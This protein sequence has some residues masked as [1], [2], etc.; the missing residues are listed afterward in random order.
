MS[1]IICSNCGKDIE[2]FKM[3]LHER[4]CSLNVRKC[5]LCDEP[6][7]I[8]EYEEHKIISHPDIKC[9]FCG[10]IFRNLEYNSHE[11]IC[12]KKL[13]ECKYCGLYMKEKELKEHEY[14]CG[15]K[16][17]NC[18]YCKKSVTKLEYDLH[19]EYACEIK[20]RLNKKINKINNENKTNNFSDITKNEKDEENVIKNIIYGDK[21]K[22]ET[23]KVE[24]KK[25]RNRDDTFYEEKNYKNKY[26]LKK[27]K[28]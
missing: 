18:E 22:I 13:I 5:S 21:N 4:F 11:K 1:Y 27:K 8:D 9:T 17:I 15:S 6:I 20:L 12:T 2:S 25:K 19:L 10:K 23:N 26:N 28:K 24:L 7:Q 3:I 16:T 14:N